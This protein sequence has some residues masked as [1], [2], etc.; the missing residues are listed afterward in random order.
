MVSFLLSIQ[1]L[2]LLQQVAL[3]FTQMLRQMNLISDNQIT[4]LPFLF[5]HREAFT[6]QADFTA[7]LRTRLNY[8]LHLTI[9]RVHQ[10]LS[11]QQS[12]VEVN[13]D[14]L[15]QIIS[16]T[17]E[18]RVILNDESDIQVPCRA[19]VHTLCAIA[20]QF[21]DLTIGHT[22]RNSNSHLFT[23]DVQ[24]LFVRMRRITQSQMQLRLIVLPTETSL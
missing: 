13:S 5:I 20:F 21:N 18:Y 15:I 6:L 7:W 8:Q 1:V 4:R 22:R 19:S 3:T 23:V 24:H 12:R 17:S 10:L 11:T 2:N 16:L 9:Q 14:I